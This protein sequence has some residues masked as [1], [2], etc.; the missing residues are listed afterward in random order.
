MEK[1]LISSDEDEVIELAN[2]NSTVT[3]SLETIGRNISELS[4]VELNNTGQ[5]MVYVTV[6]L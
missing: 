5:L 3:D 4:F 1:F 6:D 2:M